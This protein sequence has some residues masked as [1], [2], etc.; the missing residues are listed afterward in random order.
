MPVEETAEA[1]RAAAEAGHAAGAPAAV[2]VAGPNKM[3]VVGI[4]ADHKS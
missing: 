2:A 3:P 4:E 1:I